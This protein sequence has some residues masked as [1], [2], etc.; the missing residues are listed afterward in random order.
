MTK[1]LLV[2]DDANL[3]Y[4]IQSGLEDVIGDYEVIVAANGLEGLAA[5]RANKPDV[6]VTDVEMPEMNGFEMVEKIRETDGDIP[7]LFA[8]AVQTPKSVTSAY[9]LGGNNYIKKPFSPEE[10]NAHIK[11][12]LKLKEGSRFRNETNCYKL[13]RFEL[14]AAHAILENENGERI[15][16]TAREAGIL[17]LLCENKGQVVKRE[18]I[19]SRYWNTEEDYFASRSL[20]VFI[21]KL[22]KHLAAEPSVKI[23]T[24]K[25]VGL[26]LVIE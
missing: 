5:Y 3:C 26:M 11:A 10:L 7:I 14:D 8:S 16:L 15:V 17:Q 12:I 24:V 19:L 6:I 20:D 13:G 23:K 1:L 22:R 2:E 4:M 21:S 25:G 18:S 9:L